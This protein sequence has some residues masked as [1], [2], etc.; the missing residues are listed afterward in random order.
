MFFSFFFVFYQHFELGHKDY[1][2][3]VIYETLR[4]TSSPIVPHVAS[5]DTYL[6]GNITYLN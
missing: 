5:T 4:K 6:D 2:L 3:A 1:I